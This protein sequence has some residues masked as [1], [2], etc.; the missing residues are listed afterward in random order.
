MAAA[1]EMLLPAA[2]SGFRLVRK[3]LM[4]L[5]DNVL[6]THTHT[7]THTQVVQCVCVM[8]EQQVAVDSIRKLFSLLLHL[9]WKQSVF[10]VMFL[11]PLLILAMCVCVC[12]CVCVCV[13]VQPPN[14]PHPSPHSSL[15]GPAELT[16]TIAEGEINGYPC[17]HTHTHT[18]SKVSE[19]YT[20]FCNSSTE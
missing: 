18:Q 13:C 6:H 17:T 5:I 1:E 15:S 9:G 3:C 8:R 12:L 2:A 19:Q 11:L 16:Y 20:W 14:N 10:R 7:H 4:V